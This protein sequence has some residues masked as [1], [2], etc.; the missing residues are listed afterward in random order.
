MKGMKQWNTASKWRWLRHQASQS[1]L[2]TLKFGEVSV[3]DTIPKWI[4]VI[5]TTGHKGICKLFCTIQIKVMANTRQILHMVKGMNCRLLI[6]VS[7]R[8]NCC[9]ILLA[10]FRV[11]FS[12]L[13]LTPKSSVGNM[14]IFIPLSFIPDK[15]EFSFAW[16]QFQFIHQ[17]PRPD[18]LSTI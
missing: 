14:E 8:W 6:Y 17:D 9:Q 7:G 4:A 2:N 3:H 10:R 13:V 16:I 15:E 18:R 5:E 11:D 1:L 12:V